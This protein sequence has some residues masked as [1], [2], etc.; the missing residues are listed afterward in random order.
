MENI[1]ENSD[2]LNFRIERADN[3]YIV[4][5]MDECTMDVFEDAHSG[6][7][8]YV[9]KIAEAA[10]LQKMNKECCE[11]VELSITITTIQ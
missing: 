2:V 6:L 1:N 9:G 5:D 11:E 7:R 10:V 3:G 8:D 4:E